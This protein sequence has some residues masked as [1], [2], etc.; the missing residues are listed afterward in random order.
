MSQFIDRRLNSKN[1]SAVNR[2]RFL[3]RYKSQIKKA[4]TDAVGKRSITDLE[5]GE[6][7]TLP[8][9]DIREPKFGHTQGG[10]SERVHPGNKEF[11][12]GDTIQRP[13]SGGG[14]KG[15]GNEASADGEGFCFSVIP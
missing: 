2:Q 5:K 13:P 1:K 12:T 3:K 10:K 14:G 15:K 6:N 8:S 9:K 7:I 4:V 11:I